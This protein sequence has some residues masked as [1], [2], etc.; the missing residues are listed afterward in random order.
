MPLLPRMVE[1]ETLIGKLDITFK[2]IEVALAQNQIDMMDA[3][4]ADL[5][6]V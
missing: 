5:Q 4:V 2:S 6:L 1:C 3:T